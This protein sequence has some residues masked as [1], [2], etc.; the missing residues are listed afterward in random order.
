MLILSAVAAPVFGAEMNADAI[1]S[2][3]PSK[4]TRR[5]FPSSDARSEDDWKR[6]RADEMEHQT[7]HDTTTGSPKLWARW[8]QDSGQRP[9]GSNRRLRH[10]RSWI[11]PASPV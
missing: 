4:K 11:A 1:N 5:Q 10:E 7:A 3:E 9:G 8:G 2:A 6:L